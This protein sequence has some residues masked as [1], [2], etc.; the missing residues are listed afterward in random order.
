ML[1]KLKTVTLQM[2][3]GANIATIVIMWL[4]GYS[5]R[6]NPSSHPILSNAGLVFPVFL[7]INLGFL[8]FWICF[9][10]KGMVIAIA[11][12]VLCYVPIRKYSPLNISR[13]APKD[14]IKVL[15][16]NV[17]LFAGWE[18]GD[19]P[20]N[21]ILE[22]IKQQA[23]D[24]VCLQESATNEVGQQKVDSILNP[25]YAYRDTARRGG[26]DCMSIYSKYPILEKEH[27]DYSSRGNL[28]TAFKLLIDGE[29]VIVI[30]NHLETTGLTMEEKGQFKNLI[31]GDLSG[32]TAKEA[33]KL[34][35][36][37][38][39]ASTKRRAPQAEA[40]ARYIAYHSG[41]PMIVCGD[42]NDGPI[43]YAHR[44]IANGLT[45]CYIATANG[46]G[47]SYHHSGFFV[48]IDNILCTDE[49]TPY[50]CKVD[51][52]IKTSDHYPIYCWLKKRVNPKK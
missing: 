40:V 31:K 36:K 49:F 22:Y 48:R 43:S 6:L 52:K 4:V 3:G 27:I 30:N 29:V 37:K 50:G 11:G 33:S 2:I 20:S 9:K 42:F 14:A 21:P 7:L 38:L 39:G 34:L 32:D 5:D 16:Y 18:D 10:P 45:D 17:W 15:S 47:I 26:S 24:I 51:S 23:A 35:V 19:N 1:K 46:P 41:T 12:F 25:I 44:T 28:S 8:I 13:D